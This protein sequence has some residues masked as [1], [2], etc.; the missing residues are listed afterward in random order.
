M[1]YY[2]SLKTPEQANYKTINLL[3]NRIQHV[4]ILKT[5]AMLIDKIKI[6]SEQMTI[7]L[8]NVKNILLIC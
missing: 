2:H 1:N 5:N 4:I 7:I 8:A 6:K 3:I